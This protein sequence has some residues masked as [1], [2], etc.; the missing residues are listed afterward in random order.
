MASIEKLDLAP[1]RLSEAARVA[2]MSRRWIEHG[3]E[4]RYRPE[5]IARKIRD[6]ET[7]VVV[8]RAAGVA[9]GFA[10]MEFDFE[11]RRAHLVLLAVEPAY[12]RRGVGGSL[13]QW[14]DDMSRLAGVGRVGLELR[15]DNQEARAFYERLGFRAIGLHR[16]YYDARLDAIVMERRAGRE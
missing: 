15:A 12:R 16:G 7:E 10:V 14:L 6:S 9:I 1:A 11:A 2:D 5:S 3:L 13:F 8:A 4:W